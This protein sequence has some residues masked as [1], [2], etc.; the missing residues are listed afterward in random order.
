LFLINF[1]KGGTSGQGRNLPAA[2][3]ELAGIL[4][5]LT[6]SLTEAIRYLLQA[7]PV[8]AKT[9]ETLR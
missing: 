3:A 4:S 1:L 8:P 7:E 9:A 2:G 5:L 6:A